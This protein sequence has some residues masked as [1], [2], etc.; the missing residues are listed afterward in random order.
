MLSTNCLGKISKPMFALISV[1]DL[2][3]LQ[4]S[5]VHGAEIEIK[6]DVDLGVTCSFVRSDSSNLTFR[7]T[8]S[9]NKVARFATF[10][11]I[12]RASGSLLDPSTTTGIRIGPSCAT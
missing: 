5:R 9:V 12:F 1:H 3:A 6:I 2:V 10:A 7:I 11:R 4:R 8:I